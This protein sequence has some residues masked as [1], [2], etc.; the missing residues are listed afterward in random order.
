MFPRFVATIIAFAFA[1]ST[2]A[3]T[4]SV[5]ADINTNGLASTEAAL[6]SKPAPDANDLFALGGVRFLR[7]IE[8]TLQA[9][10][11]HGLSGR[12]M[13]VPVLRLDVAENPAAEPF[14]PEL[15]Q[16]IFTGVISDMALAEEPLGM[17][18]DDAVVGVRIDLA[19][20]WFDI[21]MN[22]A[23][24]RGEG[25]VELAAGGIIPRRFG[26]GGNT[27]P[28]TIRFD[29]A[30]VAWLRAY[31]HF[32]SGLSDLVLAYPP[33]E[34]IELVLS[35]HPRMKEL[36][37]DAPPANAYDYLFSTEVDL[38]MMVYLAVQQNPRAEHTRSARQHFLTMIRLNKQFWAAL[39]RETDNDA[40]WIPNARQV[41]ALGIRMPP[42]TGKVWLSVLQ[43]A[44]DLLE[45][46]KLI[47]H[48][49]FGSQA[50]VNLKALLENPAP[51][52]IAEWIQGMGLLPYAEK[53][54]R[55]G[56]FNWRNFSRMMRGESLLFAILLN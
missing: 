29:T 23:R 55:V 17:I 16:E 27:A 45:G 44:E 12:T 13:D 49:R 25:I 34:A 54:T 53:G 42:E 4:I 47:P 48:W 41:S 50:G 9:R 14:Y 37:A 40:E 46:R 21:N 7:A 22:D 52:N 56:I 30:D 33:A 11:R 6:A 26:Q 10:Y 43:D 51:I 18:S 32:L 5:S 20:L 24:D 19:D 36:V 2:A 31:T 15:I 35:S 3:Q 28:P 8:K 1:T 38:A 39:D